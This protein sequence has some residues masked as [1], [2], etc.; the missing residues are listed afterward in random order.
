MFNVIGRLRD[1]IC[2]VAPLDVFLSVRKLAKLRGVKKFQTNPNL[3]LKLLRRNFSPE[4]GLQPTFYSK[5][6][7]NLANRRKYVDF[8][9]KMVNV[10]LS[11]T[12][13]PCWEKLR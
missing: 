10:K 5:S 4:T 8:S 13:N 1:F 2:K 9:R 12:L 3:R 7:A 11:P 6:T